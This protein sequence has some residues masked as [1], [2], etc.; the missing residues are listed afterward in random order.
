[1][2]HS[3]RTSIAV[4]FFDGVHLGHRAILADAD[5]AVTFR[6]HPR[7][8]LAPN[9][10]PK[11]ILSLEERV[12]AIHSAGVK[13]IEVLDFSDRLAAMSPEEF[14]K[15]LSDSTYAVKDHI[16]YSCILAM[17]LGIVLKLGKRYRL[18]YNHPRTSEK[19]VSVIF[20]DDICGN[21]RRLRFHRDKRC[22]VFHV[23]SSGI[24]LGVSVTLREYSHALPLFDHSYGFLYGA[25]VVSSAVNGKRAQN[26]NEA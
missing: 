25:N 1:M 8:I 7:E 16:C 19:L 22:A 20:S 4:G 5:I 2:C 17:S 15:I 12:R 14:V 23:G 9:S 13:D 24:H 10:A 6:D 21:H 11:L 26:A 3:G 18:A